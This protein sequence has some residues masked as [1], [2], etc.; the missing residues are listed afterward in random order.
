MREW[1]PVTGRIDVRHD[2]D[3]AVITLD[4]PEKLNALTV[5]M[6]RELAAAIRA[7]GDGTQGRGIVLTGAGRAFS[8]GEDLSH[9]VDEARNGIDSVIE[10]F[11]DITR[12]LLSTKVPTVAALNGLA[13]GGASEITLCCD[14]RLGSA[15]AGYFM[16]EN[17]LGLTISNASSHLLPRLLKGGAAT[18]LVLDAR[19]VEAQEA[20]E[21]GLLDEIVDAA[22]LVNAAVELVL[23]WTSETNATA[24]HLSLLRPDLETIEEAFRR[25][26]AAARTVWETGATADGIARFWAR[27]DGGAASTSSTAKEMG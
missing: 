22:D 18:R 24:A 16:P 23:R 3:V 8:A 1:T 25:E 10:L 27:R 20:L 5:D 13:V 14:A 2:R 15:A 12:A 21:L 9:T 11:H 6:R 7:F 4:R 26:T 17:G 19:R